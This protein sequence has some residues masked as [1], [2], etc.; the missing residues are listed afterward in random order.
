MISHEKS[1]AQDL[2][3]QS[4]LSP[5][6]NKETVSELRQR[7]YPKVS[8]EQ[9]AAAKRYK[10]NDADRFETLEPINFNE[11][12][13]QGSGSEVVETPC[14]II[15]D[16]KTEMQLRLLEKANP[17]FVRPEGQQL[18][19]L[20][21]VIASEQNVVPAGDI[22]ITGYAGAGL[23]PLRLAEETGW[24][25]KDKTAVLPTFEMVLTAGQFG[26]P[27]Y[28]P[29]DK[30]IMKCVKKS[31]LIDKKE[32]IYY[33]NN[34]APEELRNTEVALTTIE[35]TTISNYHR[36]YR[37]VKTRR[38]I[39][40]KNRRRVESSVLLMERKNGKKSMA[41]L[42]LTIPNLPKEDLTKIAENFGEVKRRVIQKI[43][44]II[45]PR[46]GAPMEYVYRTEIQ[47]ERYKER[48]ELAYHLHIEFRSRDLVKH[49]GYFIDADEIRESWGQA[50]SE[51]LEYEIPKGQLGA[52]IDVSTIRKSGAQY[53]AKV[54]NNSKEILEDIIE[55]YG[56]KA[57]PGQW[58]GR[59]ECVKKMLDENT[60]SGRT[61]EI[62][63]VHKIISSNIARKYLYVKSYK[64]IE[65]RSSVKVIPKGGGKPQYEYKKVGFYA[66][67]TPEGME[68]VKLAGMLARAIPSEEKEQECESPI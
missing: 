66:I 14:T 52:S 10:P 44:R 9:M 61:P 57:I 51:V 4:S 60:I 65:A 13:Y 22:Y 56:K 15:T 21:E 30:K 59:S 6:N 46:S 63:M 23:Y 38:E 37:K 29:V 32:E 45:E 26:V 55:K 1:K 41:L 11:L 53:L 25:L 62:A 2:V 42:T 28:A 40:N 48:D 58:W 43:K 49:K 19:D 8:A 34:L 16:V 18:A 54:G 47:E 3:I 20:V 39:T 36:P 24:G 64:F 31:C 27:I 35:L 12:Y 17:D 50:L 67:L 68:M 7:V 5:E 33:W